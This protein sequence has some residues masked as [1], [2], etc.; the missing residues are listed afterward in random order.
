MVRRLTIGGSALC[1]AA[2]LVLAA[3]CNSSST[4]DG[5][6][7]PASAVDSVDAAGIQHVTIEG[8]SEMTFSP[9]TFHVHPGTIV[10]VLQ[11]TG[12]APHDLT[13]DDNRLHGVGT[14]PGGKSLSARITVT[15]PGR[16]PF[17]C[18]IHER[19]GM[20]GTMIVDPG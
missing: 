14:T 2:G 8:T 20:R 16:Y 19:Q 10:L 6:H 15:K 17:V 9:A 3:G 18:T 4:S 11:D 12:G 5:H 7:A 1:V 13:F